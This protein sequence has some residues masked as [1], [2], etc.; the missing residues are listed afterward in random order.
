M[1]KVFNGRDAKLAPVIDIWKTLIERVLSW[2]LATLALGLIFKKPLSDFLRRVTLFKGVGFEVSAP[3][4][5][6]Q[7]QLESGKSVDSDPLALPVESQR[8]LPLPEDIA[9]AQ[10]A[11]RNYGGSEPILLETIKK[12]EEH[13]ANVHLPLDSKETVHILIRHL[14]VTQL[15]YRAE[16]L[17]RLI[18]GSQIAFLRRLNERGAQPASVARSFFERAQHRAPHFYDGYTFSDWIGFLLRQATVVH[19]SDKDSYAISVFGQKLLEFLVAV[20]AGK[21]TH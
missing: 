7:K 17:Y 9:K 11:L 19:I 1:A 18:F 14:A 15:L 3:E 4:G 12:I 5:S 21:K 8:D 10:E 13:L 2:P 16:S 20:K 6:A